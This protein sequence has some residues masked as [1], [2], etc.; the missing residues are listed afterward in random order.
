MPEPVDLDYWGDEDL[1][2][3]VAAALLM[4]NED[5]EVVTLAD[6]IEPPAW[7]REASCRGMG[8]AVFFIARGGDNRAA[9]EV[10]QGCP[11]QVQCREAGL[12]EAAGIWGGLSERQ[13]QQE[14]RRRRS[15][16]A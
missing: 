15:G 13:R 11:V 9:R 4:T 1:G 2:L 16:A 12:G 10:C 6:L 14:R 7:H 3:D 8:T 5:A